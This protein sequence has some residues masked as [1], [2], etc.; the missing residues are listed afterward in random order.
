MVKDNNIHDKTYKDLFS[1]KDVFIKLIQNYVRDTWGSKLEEEN[2]SLIDKSFIR[3][4]EAH[5]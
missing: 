1:N 2:L 4:E 5:V 3:S